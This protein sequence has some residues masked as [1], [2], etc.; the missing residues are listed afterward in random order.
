M[1]VKSNVVLVILGLLVVLAGAVNAQVLDTAT[2]QVV[3]NIPQS[4]WVSVS[5][6]ELVFEEEDF[7]TTREAVLLE[8][9]IL[10]HKR[11]AVRVV[12]GGNVGHALFVSSL[13]DAFAGPNGARLPSS[14]MGY[15]MTTANDGARWYELQTK[16]NTR[17]AFFERLTAGRTVF[18]MDYR[19]LTT[20]QDAPG[21]YE[22]TIVYTVVPI[23]I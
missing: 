4:L 14:Q 6:S 9:G 13:E 5:V 16:T 22:G 21:T 19:L 7:D 11:G 1:G 15:R 17:E 2:I 23:E 8:E 18:D 20:W 12:V 3:L 10:A